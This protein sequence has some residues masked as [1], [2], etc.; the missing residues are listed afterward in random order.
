MRLFVALGLPDPIRRIFEGLHLGLSGARRIPSHQLHLTLAFLGDVG[1]DR[2]GDVHAALSGVTGPPVTLR[3]ARGGTFGSRAAPTVLWS[4]VERD[5]PLIA[6]QA[7]VEDAL[8]TIGFERPRRAFVPHVTLARLKKPHRSQ[9]AQAVDAISAAQA[10]PQ[11][12][13]T[14]ALY[15]SAL[16]S[17]G[18]TYHVEHVYPLKGLGAH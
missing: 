11:R 2:Q 1:P 3:L 15:S 6:L 14:F 10:P 18:A 12:V 4:A 5:P 8:A 9:L 17:K 7:R 13:D 16:S